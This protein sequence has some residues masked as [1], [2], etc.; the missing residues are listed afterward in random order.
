M[1]NLIL[2]LVCLVLGLL[3]QHVKSLPKDAH[4]TLNSLILHV[5]LPALALITI[6]L[7]K[8]DIGLIS[9]CLAP[10]ILFACSF[11]FFYVLGKKLGW[12][13][14]VIGCLTLT[15]GLGNTAF[16]GFPVIEAVYGK[17]AL[18]LAVLLDQPG[19]FL[20]VSSIGI[21]VAAH[22]SAGKLRKRDLAR[23]VAF[24][25][26]FMAFSMALILGFFG[27]E[28]E[29]ELKNILERL[30]SI[31]TP[32][33]LISVGL[34]LKIGELKHDLK[35]LSIGLGFK[36]ILSPLIIFALYW[37]L[38]LPSLVFKVAVLESAM[39]PMITGSIVAAANNLHP[40]LAGTMLG[41]GVPL[42]FLTLW[43]W[44]SFL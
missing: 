5:P 27:W 9:L 17:E 13:D 1:T 25:P 39:A 23:K 16:V 32:L 2:L 11:V 30:A 35:Y 10:W 28:A 40:R 38:H 18:K 20:I 34:Q 36:L 6:P 37:P 8:F 42:S 22:Y 12:S 7:L 4:L 33:A 26:P 31:L 3:L 44:Y 15:A 29:G 19:S 21:W 41:V 24:F 14:S 43:A